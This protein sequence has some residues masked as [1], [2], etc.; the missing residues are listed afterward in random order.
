MLPGVSACLGT[1]LR[2]LGPEAAVRLPLEQSGNKL[3]ERLSAERVVSS[4][5][6]PRTLVY[7]RAR[8]SLMLAGQSVMTH[9]PFSQWHQPRH[10][11]MDAPPGPPPHA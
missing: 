5:A 2:G 4:S 11:W 8:G 10:M 7:A 1:A 6:S 3:V 9:V